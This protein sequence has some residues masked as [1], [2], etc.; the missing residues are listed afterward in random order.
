MDSQI[1]NSLKIDKSV[2]TVASPGDVSQDRAYWHS[3]TPQE[4]LA[5]V[6]YLRVMNYGYDPV[7]D[8]LQRVLTVSELGAS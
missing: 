2:I 4:R 1:L 8:R 5:V 6:E 7:A 3:R